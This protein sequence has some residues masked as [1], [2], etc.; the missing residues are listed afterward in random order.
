[1]KIFDNLKYLN[2]FSEPDGHVIAIISVS[3]PKPKYQIMKVCL[4]A[5]KEDIAIEM[6]WKKVHCS[7]I[8]HDLVYVGCQSGFM[9][10]YRIINHQ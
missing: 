9:Q 10:E 7:I 5:A 3:E 6:G 1:M 4:P 2:V 8:K